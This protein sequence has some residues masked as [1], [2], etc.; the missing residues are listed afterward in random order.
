M[1]PNSLPTLTQGILELDET[2]VL[3]LVEERLR[4]GDDPLILLEECQEGM[5]QVGARY[6]QQEYYLSGLMMAGEIFRE[7][8]ELV[9]PILQE[10][11]YGRESGQ[12]LLGTVQGDIHDIGKNMFG[13]MLRCH[14]FTVA[15]L[16]VDVKPAAF[17]EATEKNQPDIVGLSGLLTPSY[18][19][20][21]QT[22]Q[23]IRKSSDS[24][25]AGIPVIIGGGILNPKICAY[26]GADYWSIDSMVG[27]NLCKQIMSQ[28]AR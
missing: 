16:G 9:E 8:M 3:T 10:R 25:I 20:M 7:V 22:I 23:L 6:E 12:I 21:R 17:L 15:D 26:V 28:G 2:G 18:E 4:R 27:V 24:P 19:T 13:T 1:K 11:L 14:G 5:R